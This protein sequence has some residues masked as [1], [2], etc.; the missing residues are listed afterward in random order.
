[1]VVV[2]FRSKVHRDWIADPLD[3]S[4]YSHHRL[5]RYGLMNDSRT[6]RLQLRLNMVYVIVSNVGGRSL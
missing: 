3:V 4:N 2:P 5:T 6:D 1:M